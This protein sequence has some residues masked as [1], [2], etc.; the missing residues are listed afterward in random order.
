M[1]ISS[2]VPRVNHRRYRRTR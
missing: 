2:L 1:F